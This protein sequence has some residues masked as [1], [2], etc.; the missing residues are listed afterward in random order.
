[1]TLSRLCIIGRWSAR[2]EKDWYPW[3]LRELQAMQPPPF[4]DIQIPLMPEPDTPTIEGWRDAIDALNPPSSR[5]Q[6]LLVGHS[7]G[8]Q[9]ILHFLAKT[10]SLPSLPPLGGILFVAGW[11]TVDRP[12]ETIRPWLEASHDLPAI[13]RAAPSIRVLVSDND[14]F[15]ADVTTTKALFEERLGANVSVIP[16]AK[17]FNAAE[18]PDV[19]SAILSMARPSPLF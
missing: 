14:P 6:T 10:A 13:R 7:V 2:P 19:L 12:W 8:C 5:S 3:L 15:T 17:H 1:M 9:A 16:H 18:E 4:E 11:W